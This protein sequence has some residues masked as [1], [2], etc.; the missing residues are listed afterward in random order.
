MKERRIESL[1]VEVRYNSCV[2]GLAL[3]KMLL[4]H[5]CFSRATIGKASAQ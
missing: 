3:G 4:M 2:E 5:V 1:C